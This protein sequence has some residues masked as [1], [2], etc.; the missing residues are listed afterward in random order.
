M[1][2]DRTHGSR[3]GRA[4]AGAILAALLLAVPLRA[5]AAEYRIDDASVADAVEDELRL[6]LTVPV[7][8]VD[9]GVA[10]G[11][12]TLSGS[13]PNLLAARRAVRVAQAVRGVRAVVDRIAVV[14]PKS[15]TDAAIRRDVAD[16]LRTDPAT[17]SYR[18]EPT[19][20]DGVVTLTGT[21]ASWE[22]RRLARTIAESVRGV[23]RVEAKIDVA[24]TV[25]RPDG[26]IAQQI[27]SALAWDALLAKDPIEVR[28]ADGTATLTG[29]VGSAWEQQR[30]ASLAWVAGITAV[31]AS[32]L[33]VEVGERSPGLRATYPAPTDD[34]I[35]E[36]V[37]RALRRDPRVDR[38][39]VEVASARGLLTLRGTVGDLRARHAAE[40]DARNTVGV[41]GVRNRL[42]VRPPKGLTDAEVAA[43]LKAALHRDPSLKPYTVGVRVDGGVARLGGVVDTAAEKIRAGRIARRVR[44][45]VA[46][47]NGLVVATPDRPP[48]DP[49]M[50]DVWSDDDGGPYYQ[51][52]YY[53]SR[54]D[55]ELKDA[56]EYQLFWSPFVDADQVQVSVED[57]VATLTGRVDSWNE[58]R[59]AA[60]NAYDGGAARVRNRLEVGGR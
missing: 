7:D 19:V 42:K 26:E 32:D 9:V 3:A 24:Y 50:A 40:Q 55:A 4:A 25:D 57:G 51:S 6:R 33:T 27:R 31:D 34:G 38:S 54:T 28:V 36:A 22:A 35:A 59:A 2:R 10:D 29:A 1:G 48:Y 46:V 52:P 21:A 8:A 20:E 60:S 39:A 41:I 37:R 14:P 13:L 23:R 45:V 43:D 58:S 12:A 49:S 17:E 56:I 5:A 53:L 11:V 44:G 16:A 30:A 18:V 47:A 15:R